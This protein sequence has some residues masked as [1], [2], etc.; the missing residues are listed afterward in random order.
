[1]IANSPL[2]LLAA[3][4]I[5]CYAGAVC[6]EPLRD[7]GDAN[8]GRFW[9]QLQR[10]EQG[11]GRDPVR[12]MQLGD[13]HTAGDYFTGELRNRLQAR[14]GNAGYGWLSPGY[15]LN[16]R[17]NQ[18]LLRMSG[19]WVL[20]NS[21]TTAAN[22]PLGGYINRAT[23]GS[24]LEVASK[25][26]PSEG[27][28]RVSIWARP[29]PAGLLPWQAQLSN[30]EVRDFGTVDSQDGWSVAQTLVEATA[31]NPL[32]IA[33]R[34]DNAELGA[35][36]LDRLAPGVSVD[37]L[38][39]NGAQG[40]VTN[41]WDVD[42]VARQLAWRQPDL[43]IIAFGTNE[44]FDSHFDADTFATD[45]RSLV[46]RLRRTAPNSAIL[47]LGAPSSAKRKSAAINMG[48]GVGIAP[49]LPAVQRIQREIARQQKTLYWD[50][51]EMMGGVCGATQ[52]ARRSPALV[53][54]DLVHQTAEGYASSGAAFYE[55]LMQAYKQGL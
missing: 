16:Q 18:A 43:L 28:W 39:V 9:Q 31:I 20:L 46:Q 12:I 32:R 30:N 45:L 33:A 7:F 34:A 55:A 26:A 17:S 44:A 10:L 15:V 54:Q 8:A 29:T 13:S 40:T 2:R 36:V 41:R 48:C 11:T 4:L 1:M 51:A 47:I 23:I 42:T 52:W 24:S 38:G 21:R 14:F 53:S 22:Y 25:Y 35:I 49:G 3:L 37:A 50:W 5:S 27:L 19:S 6:A